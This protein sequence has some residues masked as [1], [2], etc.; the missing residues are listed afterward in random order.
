[1]SVKLSAY[2]WDGC[3]SAGIKGTKLLILARLADFSSDEGISWPSVDTIARQIGAG[4]STVITAVGEL[5]R[6]G[7]L[8]RKERRQGQRSG[9]NIYTLNVPRLRQAAAGAYSQ[10]PVSEHSESGRS[11]SEGS[12]AGRPESERPENR[13]NGASQGPESGHDPSV[14]SKQEPSD[15]KPSR[16]VVGQPDAEQ[17]I[18]DKAIAVLKHLNLVTGARYQNS[19]SSLENIRARLR[20]GHSVDDLQL[21]VDYK[22][23]HWHDTDMYDYMRPQTLFIPSKFEGYL[24]SATRW[25]GR[26]RPAREQWEQLRQQRDNGAFRASYADVDYSKVPEGFRS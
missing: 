26:N 8:T 3:A 10:G 4:R 19:K 25:N 13:K 2:V 12:E 6:D 16:Q 7:W 1:M 5:E 22:H 21:V 17:L 9:T 18:T 11:E 23:E 20:E 24:L 14:T 15:K